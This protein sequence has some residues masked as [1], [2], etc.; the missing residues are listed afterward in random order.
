MKRIHFLAILCSLFIHSAIFAQTKTV[1][2]SGNWT[3]STD[4]S[5][6][7]S[8]P[9]VVAVQQVNI[10]QTSDKLTI[11]SINGENKNTYINTLDTQ[12]ANMITGAGAKITSTIQ[13]NGEKSLKR[14]LK[15]SVPNEYD[16]LQYTRDEQWELSADNKTLTMAVTVTPDGGGDPYSFIAVYSKQ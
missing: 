14:M 3:L 9:A 1:D 4:K 11:V 12:P 5:S 13:P 15:V 2:F 6:F 8:L 10:T 16:K 7:G